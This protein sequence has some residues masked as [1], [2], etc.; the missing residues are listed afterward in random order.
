MS[1]FDGICQLHHLDTRGSGAGLTQEAWVLTCEISA[2][3]M[4]CLARSTVAPVMQ[5]SLQAACDLP[6]LHVVLVDVILLVL[7]EARPNWLF[8][9]LCSNRIRTEANER[10]HNSKDHV[11]SRL[12]AAAR[13]SAHLLLTGLGFRLLQISA[14]IPQRESTADEDL[15]D[16]SVPATHGRSAASSMASAA[17]DEE[18]LSSGASSLPLHMVLTCASSGQ[19]APRKYRRWSQILTVRSHASRR[20]YRAVGGRY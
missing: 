9:R 14:K 10:R 16:P 1:F 6:V 17:V 18:L 20:S 12:I 13:L 4:K 7:G 11:G 19:E 2:V 8:L 15:S 3:V 5:M